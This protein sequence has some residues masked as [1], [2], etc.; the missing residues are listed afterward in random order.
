[1]LKNWFYTQRARNFIKSGFFLDFFIKKFAQKIIVIANMF[2]VFFLEKFIVEL[3][4]KKLVSIL[5]VFTRGD[6]AYNTVFMS[7]VLISVNAVIVIFI[8]V[9]SW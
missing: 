6:S 2:T 1:M 3:V 9:W 4:P 8:V 5:T 7:T